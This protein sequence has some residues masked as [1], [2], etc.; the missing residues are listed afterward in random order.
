MQCI[1]L[2]VDG[3]HTAELVAELNRAVPLMDADLV[4]VYVRGHGPRHGL[5]MVRHRPGGVGMPG[6]RERGIAEAEGVRGTKALDEAEEQGRA[7]ARSVRRV[8]VLGEPGRSVVDIAARERVE[9]IAVRAEPGRI[10]PAAR[11]IVDHAPAS[12]LVLRPGR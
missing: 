8:E 12:V 1:L 4:L 2:L 3:I 11:F 7:V 9:L 5:D 10:G 6:P